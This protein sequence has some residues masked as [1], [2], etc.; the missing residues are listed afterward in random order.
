MVVA[1]ANSSGAAEDVDDS[2]A[3]RW[4]VLSNHGNVLVCI[5]AEPDS[6]LRD[7]ATRVGITER[8]VFGIVEDLERAGVLRRIKVGRRNRYEIDPVQSL[9][10]DVVQGRTVGDLLRALQAQPTKAD[11]LKL[12]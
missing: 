1:K 8:A 12:P 4:K 10:H 7:L 2:E 11:E 6:R 5:A 3:R 9:R